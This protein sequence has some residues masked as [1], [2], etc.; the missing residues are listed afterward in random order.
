MLKEEWRNYCIHSLERKDY[1]VKYL[2]VQLRL[3]FGKA[4]DAYFDYG[5]K[6]A[7]SI[8]SSLSDHSESHVLL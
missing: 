3:L 7:V 5:G 6:V 8:P 2:L 4:Y 1:Q